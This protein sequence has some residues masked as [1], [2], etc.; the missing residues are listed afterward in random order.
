MP[1]RWISCL[2]FTAVIVSAAAG[3]ELQFDREISQIFEANCAGCHSPKTKTSGF[4]VATLETII[5]G[6]NKYGRAVI[7]GH[8]DQSPLVKLLKGQLQ[9]KMPVGSSLAPAE[10]A[11]IERWISELPPPK[12]VQSANWRWPF[13]KPVKSRPPAVKNT[14]WVKNPIDSFVLDRVEQQGLAPAPMAAKR[15]LGRRAFLD[16]VGL[17]PTVAEMKAFLEDNSPAA[18]EHLVDRLLAD[19]RY[20]E[21]WGRHWLDLARYGETSGLEGDGAIGNVWRY[22]DWVIEAFNSNMPYDRFVMFS[23]LQAETSIARPA[24]TTSPTFKAMCQ[25]H[26]CGWLP[27]TDRTW[28]PPRCGRTTWPK[29][30]ARHHPSFLGLTRR[31]RPLPRS[32]IRSHS[33]EGLLSLSGV[34]QCSS[35]RPACRGSVQGQ[36]TRR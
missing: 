11:R 25:R 32:Q 1:P 28:W 33:A 10:L 30:L 2:I 9:P 17:P 13:E 15:T 35:S 24:T 26:F 20:G 7:E 5:N 3:A 18:F 27:G 14:A 4:S 23:R 12:N 16:L 34:L 21:R 36:G 22:R 29:S 31:L 6:G 19:P 8:P